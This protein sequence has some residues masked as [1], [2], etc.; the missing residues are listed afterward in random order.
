MNRKTLDLIFS[1]GGVLLAVLL[2]VLGLVL[3]NQSDFAKDYVHD[4]LLEQKINFT[5]V[6]Y[7]KPE[8]KKADCLIAN[9]GKPLTTGKQA[10]CYANEYIG[11]H[12]KS[13]NGGKTYSQSSDAARE[14]AA[15]AEAAMKANPNDPAA[16]KLDADA[17]AA[18]G[19]VQALFRGETL[20][21]L[22]LTTYG[23]SIFGERANQA[24]TVAFL[25]AA[26]LVLASIAGF[27]HMATNRKE[28][29]SLHVGA[30][31]A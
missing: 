19:K 3:K 6:Q 7:L 21:G 28:H 17:K 20:R 14:L 2:L 13:I 30:A 15:K 4:Q 25:V 1:A 24:A 10:E 9:A 11:L 16:Q 31:S 8:E 23:F 12:V 26:V 5:P 22:L 29:V 18:D 27:V